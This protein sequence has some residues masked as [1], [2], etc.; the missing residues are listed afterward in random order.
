M[1]NLEENCPCQNKFATELAWGNLTG[2][3]WSWQGVQ[4]TDKHVAWLRLGSVTKYLQYRNSYSRGLRYCLLEPW[5]CLNTKRDLTSKGTPNHG[6]VHPSPFTSPQWIGPSLEI[7]QNPLSVGV[8]ASGATWVDSIRICNRGRT[9][10]V[11]TSAEAALELH[12][13][14]SLNCLRCWIWWR[15]LTFGAVRRLDVEFSI[16]AN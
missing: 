4:A 2:K 3:R 15:E 1:E 6:S 16:R 5:G 13:R 14:I 8:S 10:Q 12:D 9:E 7:Q 11:G